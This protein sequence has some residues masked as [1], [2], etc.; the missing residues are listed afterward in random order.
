MKEYDKYFYFFIYENCMIEIFCQPGCIK[1]K[2]RKL[3]L[4]F[5]V[6]GVAFTS[7]NSE[8]SRKKIKKLHRPNSMP[9]FI[10]DQFLR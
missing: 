9:E 4:L 6:Y 8:I 10:L 7:N 1:A 3:R 2:A 5:K